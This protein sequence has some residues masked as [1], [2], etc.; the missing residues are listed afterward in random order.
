[1]TKDKQAQC[2]MALLFAN[3]DLL[4]D[5]SVLELLVLKI[6]KWRTD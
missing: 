5:I 2:V 6:I 1:M 3:R 4:H